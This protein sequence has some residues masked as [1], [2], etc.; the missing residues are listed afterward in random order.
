MN[1]RILLKAGIREAY[2]E[3]SLDS[4][5]GDQHA[6]E[7][8]KN[9]IGNIRVARANGIGL[10]AYGPNGTGKTLLS[11]EVLKAALQTINPR[12]G[13]HYTAKKVSFGE[14]V[15]FFT[16][17]W[18]SDEARREFER[19]IVGV[20]FLLIDDI[21]KAYIPANGND[22]HKAALDEV[23]RVRAER[24]KPILMTSNESPAF[25]STLFGDAVG[26]LLAGSLLPVKFEGDDYRR[27]NKARNKWASL[28][29]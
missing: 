28:T 21:E 17:G 4:F 6:L 1:S 26:S 27:E 15:T 14:I 2:H 13:R 5:K 24:K 10:Y 18:K 29:Q 3:T 16:R 9:Y 19:E 22:L 7:E 23:M 12:T 8:Y 20:D 11:C 25:I